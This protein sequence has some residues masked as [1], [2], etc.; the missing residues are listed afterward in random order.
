MKDVF[1]QKPVNYDLRRKHLLILP[2]TTTQTFG[3]NSLQFRGALLWNSLNKDITQCVSLSLLKQ[4]L[5][6]VEIICKCK[7]C[8]N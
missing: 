5:Q 8:M 4:K 3:N 7:L 6:N 1:R 2:K